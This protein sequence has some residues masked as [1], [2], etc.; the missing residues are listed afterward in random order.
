AASYGIVAYQTA[1][2]KAH[3]PAEFMAA[4][5]SAESDAIEKVAEAVAECKEM[6]MTVLS[7]DANESFADFTVIDDAT[8]RFGL[9][10]I[11]NIGSHIVEVIIKERKQHGPYA[12]ITDFLKRVA[13][14]DLNRKSL[15]AFVKSGALDGLAGRH[16]LFAN[17]DTLIAYA[18]N[19]H[20]AAERN[21]S[22]LF[23]ASAGK[24]HEL[25]LTEVPADAAASLAWEKELL[26]LYVSGHPLDAYRAL[27]ATSPATIATLPASGGAV[28]LCALVK[29][30]KE[31]TTKRGE[32]MAFVTLEDLTGTAEAIAF[33]KLYAKHRVLLTANRLVRVA[34]KT[35]ERNGGLQL[36]IDRM[37]PLENIPSKAHA[38]TP[39]GESPKNAPQ[40]A[41][42]L[43]LRLEAGTSPDLIARLR[44]IL[45]NAQGATPVVIRINGNKKIRL[46]VRVD[47]SNGLTEKL[48][49]LVG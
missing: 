6:G 20:E 49:A 8:I 1:Y 32:L 9:S 27:L 35:E 29:E 44:E 36:I 4:L 43:E 15:E 16:T 41:H 3:Y 26:G 33:P 30:A 24:N 46:P 48:K 23:G 7:P 34:G 17:I 37:E 13:D 39:A 22:S 10:A 47:T 42:M 19:E 25:R 38:E 18:K 40:P 5:M 31:I 12:T 14:R 45:Y 2:M 11:K 21:Q 28:T